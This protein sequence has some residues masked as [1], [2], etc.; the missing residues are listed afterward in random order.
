MQHAA[1]WVSR[2]QEK[3]PT[4]QRGALRAKCLQDN[5]TSDAAG[6]VAGRTSTRERNERSSE[7]RGGQAVEKRK[8]YAM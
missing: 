8:K 5:E 7:R 1:R 4:M 2:Q 6:G 3:K